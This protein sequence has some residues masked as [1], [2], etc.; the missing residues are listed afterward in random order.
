[1]KTSTAIQLFA[2][3]AMAAILLISYAPPKANAEGLWVLLSGFLGFL[4]RDLL[5]RV[6]GDAAAPADKQGGHALPTL[7][8]VLALV[9]LLAGCSLMPQRI[10]D[11]EQGV[12]QT[13]VQSAERTVCRDIPIG[14][15]LRLYAGNPE[16]IK[17]WQAICGNPVISPLNDA[18]VAAILKAYPSFEQA[19]GAV[20]AAVT[21]VPAAKP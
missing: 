11:I 13:A 8:G 18:T 4:V 12:A 17:G 7:L 5:P 20:G 16:R 3:L 6:T 9:A 1:M 14:T 21:L 2:A 19:A 15:W 10:N